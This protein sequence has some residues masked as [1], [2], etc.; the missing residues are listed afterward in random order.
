MTQPQPPEQDVPKQDK[1]RTPETNIFTFDREKLLKRPSARLAYFRGIASTKESMLR[2][3]RFMRPVGLFLL[4]CVILVSALHILTTI[5]QYTPHGVSTL[6]I[7]DG[8]WHVSAGA[9]TIAIDAIALYVFM[10]SIVSY[11]ANVQRRIPLI[12]FFIV[13][14]GLLNGVFYVEVATGIP[15]GLSQFVNESFSTLFIVFMTLLFPVSML[16]IKDAIKV[17][18]E[19]RIA[20][21]IESVTL[22][23]YACGIHD[24]T[25]Q[26]RHL[27][28]H[29]CVMLRHERVTSASGATQ[30]QQQCDAL[31]QRVAQLEQECDRLMSERV[32]FESQMTQWMT[33]AAQLEDQLRQRPQL[34]DAEVI[35]LT[36]IK[37]SLRQ[38]AKVFEVS[39]A[40]VRRRIK[41]ITEQGE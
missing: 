17:I 34:P 5:A 13:L 16:T 36:H 39:E 23:E 35:E 41:L 27:V 28:R 32:T 22:N 38:A 37:L 4:F 30:V 18:E 10:T 14:T 11:F 29:L 25:T 40:T 21:E 6:E 33:Q 31:T 2:I 9:L 7:P 3:A 20:L 19:S 8:L 24:R 1:Q 26:L 12:W 15:A